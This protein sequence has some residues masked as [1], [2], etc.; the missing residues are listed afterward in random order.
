[1]TCLA[2]AALLAAAWVGGVQGPAESSADIER[3]RALTREFV[4]GFNSGDLD[5]LM[6]FYADDYVDVNLP[7]P[8][9]TKAERR[10]YYRQ[11]VDPARL[12]VEVTPDEI[13]VAGEYAFAR[14][15]IRLE[16]KGSGEEAQRRE[17]RYMEVLRRFPDG[18]KS[19]W[20]IDAETYPAVKERQ[21]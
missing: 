4:L 20:G 8:R 5:R 12:R 9:Q 21:R 17:L 19:I 10:E 11:I 2:A 18:W 15:T 6:A 3:I 7:Q 1:V 13:V 16:R 14:G